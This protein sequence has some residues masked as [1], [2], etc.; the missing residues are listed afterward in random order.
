MHSDGTYSILNAGI[1]KFHDKKAPAVQAN[2]VLVVYFEPQGM[3]DEIGMHDLCL[4]L[5]DKDKKVII[6][7]DSKMQFEGRNAVLLLSINFTFK[8]SGK[9]EFWLEM[10]GKLQSIYPIEVE[11]ADN[12][13][14]G[15]RSV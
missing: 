15:L 9:Y 11:V 8:K 14:P 2:G 13:K 10:W 3:E 5:V 6:K 12:A 7:N 1:T 4:K